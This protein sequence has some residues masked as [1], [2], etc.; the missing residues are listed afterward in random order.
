MQ[1][2]VAQM[3]VDDVGAALPDVL[4][5][6]QQLAQSRA[7]RQVEVDRLDAGRAQRTGG[8]VSVE[9]F[10]TGHL[11]GDRR[12]RSGRGELPE[13]HLRAAEYQMVDQGE[14]A[15]LA[16]RGPDRLQGVGSLAQC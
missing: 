5:H 13:Q 3:G 1:I 4:P 16:S 15:Q 8:R 12:R 10:E 7:T 9:L 11:Q 6:L 14:D 2:G